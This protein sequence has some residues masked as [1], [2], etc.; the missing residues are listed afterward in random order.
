MPESALTIVVKLNVDLAN[1]IPYQD[2]VVSV[3]PEDIRLAWS[4]LLPETTLDRA[5]PMV[6]SD[7]VR[8]RLDLNEQ[9][10]G[11]PSENLLA[12][13][14]ISAPPGFD[15]EALAAA[16]RSLPFVEHSYVKQQFILAGVNFA[17]DPLVVAQGYLGPKPVGINAIHA[18]SKDGGDGTGVKFV[19]VENGFL[20]DHEDLVDPGGAIR[21]AVLPT[22]TPSSNINDLDHSTAVLGVVLATDNSR[23]IVGVAPQVQAFAASP[24][25][26]GVFDF[27][28]SL[29]ATLIS[30]WLDP[31][32]G[33]GTVVLIEYMDLLGRPVETDLFVR[34]TIRELTRSGLTVVVPAGNGGHDLNVVDDGQGRIFDRNSP[35]FFDSGAIMVSAANPGLNDRYVGVVHGPS[36]HGNR[37]DCFAWGDL[38]MTA[39][40]KAVVPGG[41]NGYTDGVSST[42]VLFGGTS[43]ASA[44]IAGAAILLQSLHLKRHGSFLPSAN[45]R[46][47]LK[48]ITFN[49]EPAPADIGRIG[50]MPDLQRLA[51]EI[52]IS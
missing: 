32:F 48:D 47:L 9:E 36:C 38:I 40:A 41:L 4:D 37:I 6:D 21:I 2:D 31:N 42:S 30:I 5:L 34:S 3:F 46:G 39:S 27:A 11:N 51:Q 17:D 19:D 23:G 8:R 12:F 1:I 25:P 35:A 16:A 20:L 29:D 24:G 10:N 28:A 13:F 26:G 15:A 18:W 44:I 22:G 45:L 14:V 7:E 33:P 50:A 43:G 52:G 49:T